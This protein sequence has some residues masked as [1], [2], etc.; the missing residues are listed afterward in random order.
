M[1]RRI[2]AAVIVITVLLGGGYLAYSHLVPPSEEGSGPVYAT[3]RVKRGDLRVAVEGVGQLQ[4]IFLSE[5]TA[6]ADGTLVA[7]HVERGQ[8]VEVGQLV[9]T[10]RNDQIGYELQELEFDLER[11][12]LELADVLGVSPDQVTRVDPNRGV[13]IVAPIGGRVAEL[14][15][16]NGDNL[17]EGQLVARVVDDSAVISR[18]ELNANQ[19]DRVSAGQKVVCRFQDFEGTVEGVVT[20]VD[21]TPVPQGSHFTY[22]ATIEIPNRGLLKPGQKFNL[23]ILTPTG[24]VNLPGLQQVDRYRGEEVVR[25]AAAGTVTSV[26]VRNMQKVSK[27][28]AIVTLGG[29]KTRRYVE[30]KQLDIRQ[31][32]LQIAQKQD[33]RDK[34]EIRSG[35]AGTV[36]WI[37]GNP[38]MQVR[39]GQ[40]IGSIFDNSRMNLHIMIDELDVVNVKEGQEATITVEALPG[41]SWTAKVLR[42][43]MMGHTEG[44]FAQYG[45]FLEVGGTEE[46][47]PGMTANVSIFV[48]EKKDALLIP[49]EAVFEEDGEAKVE[50]LTDQGPETVPVKIGLCNDRWAEVVAGLEEG[51]LVITGSS[52]ERLGSEKPPEEKEGLVLPGT[53]KTPGGKTPETKPAPGGGK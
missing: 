8:R 7:I 52:L 4:P 14:Q 40:S 33:I 38:G 37:W 43:D 1:V 49:I 5:L 31:M 35:I 24:E 41:K 20:D 30:K 44:G 23:T 19:A 28:D 36:A 17:E 15:V 51:Q 46:L 21:R 13:Q 3:A 34:L 29:E 48:G 26:N 2:L 22:S 39:A 45:C 16:K 10:L 18:V 50:I 25:S 11:A 42:V 32:E 12:R 27:G 47:K 53:G 9:A 6:A